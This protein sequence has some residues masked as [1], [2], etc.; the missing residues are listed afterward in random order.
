M[1]QYM[2]LY[3]KAWVMKKDW[4]GGE[5]LHRSKVRG[6]LNRR[7]ERGNLERG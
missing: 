7:V 2:L 3:R 5:H 4:V 6:G 1:L